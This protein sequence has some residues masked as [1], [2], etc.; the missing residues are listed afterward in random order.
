MERRKYTQ[1]S[2]ICLIL[3]I[4]A[5]IGLIV[6]GIYV[7]ANE[8]SHGYENGSVLGPLLAWIAM[9]F[10]ILGIILAIMGEKG[11]MKLVALTGNIS[12]LCTISLLV[13]TMRF[14]DVLDKILA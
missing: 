9:L 13:G 11:N 6:V 5:F 1:L 10:P 4:L 7:S 2:F 8:T 14:Y 12:V 3:C